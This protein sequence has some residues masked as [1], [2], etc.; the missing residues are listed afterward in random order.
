MAFLQ[1]RM[2]IPD[3]C[4]YI[5][6]VLQS[7]FKMSCQRINFDDKIEKLWH[8]CHGVLNFATIRD[9]KKVTFQSLKKDRF[10]EYIPFLKS[11]PTTL[12]A[13]YYFSQCTHSRGWHWV[14]ICIGQPPYPSDAAGQCISGTESA[15]ALKEA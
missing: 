6:N 4:F 15:R 2:Q 10:T 11:L 1:K 8:V 13:S 3:L 14:G 5:K 12:S 7:G 9:F